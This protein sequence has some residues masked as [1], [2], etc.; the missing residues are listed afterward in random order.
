MFR[1]SRVSG[2]FRVSGVSR[3]CRTSRVSKVSRV[4]SLRFRVKGIYLSCHNKGTLLFTIDPYYGNLNTNFF[5]K[6]PVLHLEPD[7]PYKPYLG[8][9]LPTV[10][11]GFL[12]LTE[13]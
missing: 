7:K 1:A 10:F 6:N 11:V 13:G 5:H 9:S 3:V 8:L 12:P 2:V 4:S